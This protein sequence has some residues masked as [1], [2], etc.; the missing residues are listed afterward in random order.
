MQHRMQKDEC[1][2][3]TYVDSEGAV[4]QKDED[5]Q[6]SRKAKQKNR[7]HLDGGNARRS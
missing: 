6:T 3:D 2:A 1:T 7:R 4:E 5:R